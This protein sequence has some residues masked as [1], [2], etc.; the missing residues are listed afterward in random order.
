MIRVAICDDDYKVVDELRQRTKE[1]LMQQELIADIET[2]ASG[3]FLIFDIQEKQ[4]YDL[5]LLDI[6]MPRKNGLE[7]ARMIK[8]LT[9]EALI[10]FI[11]SHTE[12]AIDSYELSI[13]RYVPKALI[14]HKVQ[15]AIRD[16]LTYIELQRNQAYLISTPTRYEKIPYKAISYI[17]KDGKYAV[18]FTIDGQET[19]IRKSLNKLYQELNTEDFVFIDRSCIVNIVHI[20]KIK[21]PDIVM[22]SDVHLP[23]SKARIPEIRKQINIFWSKTL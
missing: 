9:P 17:K 20:L 11:T 3:D 12:Y 13:F 10:I 21:F 18:I 2:Y 5:I 16:A 4:S 8:N 1:C 14:Q 22:E 7:I 6:E 23:I 19:R 15:N